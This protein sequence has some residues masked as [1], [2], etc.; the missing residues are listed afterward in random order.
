[1]KEPCECGNPVPCNGEF[2]FLVLY[3]I[4]GDG[5]AKLNMERLF[6]CTKTPLKALDTNNDRV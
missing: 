6:R 5:V 1:M 2:K 3:D 4:E